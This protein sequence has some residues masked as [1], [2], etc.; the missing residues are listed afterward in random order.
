MQNCIIFIYYSETYNHDVLVDVLW[1][2]SPRFKRLATDRSLWEGVVSIKAAKNPRRAEFIVQEC[3]NSGTHT[4]VMCAENLDDLYPVLTSPRYAEYINPTK[5]FPNLKISKP[6]GDDESI[7]FEIAW[8]DESI[9][10]DE[11]LEAF[12]KFWRLVEA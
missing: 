9:S 4:F 8:Y 10:E 6:V 3:L 11:Q 7:G 12:R 1:N 5:R 2:V